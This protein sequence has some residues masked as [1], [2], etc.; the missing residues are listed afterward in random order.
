MIASLRLPGWRDC[1]VFLV[2]LAM[3]AAPV[4][5][6]GGVFLVLGGLWPTYYAVLAVLGIAFL[7]SWGRGKIA[8]HKPRTLTPRHRPPLLP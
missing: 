7:S 8:E 6:I 3:V 2:F 1:L 4:V 5:V